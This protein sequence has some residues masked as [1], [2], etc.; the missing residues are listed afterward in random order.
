MSSVQT[1]EQQQQQ[2]VTAWLITTKQAAE[3]LNVS[4]RTIWYLVQS[5][6]IPSVKIGGATRIWLDE[7]REFAR[8]GTGNSEPS[9]DAGEHSE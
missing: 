6:K 4:Q 8:V 2:P 3:I 7:L 1:T 5:K 9:A